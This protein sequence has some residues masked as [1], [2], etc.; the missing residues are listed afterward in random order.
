LVKSKS[1]SASSTSCVQSI[2]TVS[3]DKENTSERKSD[4]ERSSLDTVVDILNR[5]NPTLGGCLYALNDVTLEK[6][7]AFMKSKEQETLKK[8]AEVVNLSVFKGDLY[9]RKFVSALRSVPEK[10]VKALTRSGKEKKNHSKDHGFSSFSRNIEHE[11]V[12]YILKLGYSDT[13]DGAGNFAGAV[14]FDPSGTTNWASLA[15]LFD[16]FRVIRIHNYL[17]PVAKYA[18]T[19]VGYYSITADNDSNTN[20]LTFDQNLQY[21]IS[22]QFSAWET[23]VYTYTRPDITPSAYW[24]DCASPASSLGCLLI[25]NASASSPISTRMFWGSYSLE[26]QFRSTR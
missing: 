24:C 20:S 16:E 1:L 19:T 6:N 11:H 21:A 10:K 9:K 12:T 2:K 8:E 23:N 15:A 3:S 7:I 25:N 22:R 17:T 13:T 18:T 5:E 26:V 14:L 4:G